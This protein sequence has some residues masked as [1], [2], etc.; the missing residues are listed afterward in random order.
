MGL[1]GVRNK[2]SEAAA[3]SFIVAGASLAESL[4]TVWVVTLFRGP[5]HHGGQHP[6]TEVRQQRRDVELLAH[7]RLETGALLLGAGILQ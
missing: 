7:A 1:I 2:P 4:L 3:E 5:V 6:F